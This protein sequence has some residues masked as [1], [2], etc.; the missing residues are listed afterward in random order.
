M[1]HRILVSGSAGF[2]GTKLCQRLLRDGHDVIGV[3]SLVEQVHHGQKPMIPRGM[4]FY[5]ADIGDREF[6]AKLLK[7]HSID[8]IFHEAAE[9]GVAQSMYEINQY[10]H[11]NIDATGALMDVLAK[12][13]H[14]VKKIMVAGSAAS[15]GE[16]SY[17]CPKCATRQFPNPRTD[18]SMGFEYHCRDCQTQLEIDYIRESDPV[19]P[20]SIYGLTKLVQEQL[21]L[22]TGQ[23]YGIDAVALR[24]FNIMGA[25]QSPTNPYTGVATLFMSRLKENKAPLVFEDGKQVRDFVSV[26][27][28]VNANVLAMNSTVKN[29]TFNI[30]GGQR[31]TVT[32]MVRKLA[33]H[34]N[35][36]IEPE[37]T[38]KFRKGDTR[39]LQA[40]ITAAKWALDYSPQHTL[41]DI[42]REIVEW[43]ETIKTEDHTDRAFAELEKHGMLGG[44]ND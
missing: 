31:N 34:M 23:A 39:H 17:T 3:D 19:R 5:H 35:K 18:V 37:I 42:L 33:L 25:G 10:V 2:L 24:Y 28:I 30:G 4:D 32:D 27:D 20:G 26:H 11:G 12:S 40:D 36:P 29:G 9:V 1:K 14:G 15:Y 7:E 13:N 6:V 44:R 38:G 41:D 43:S 22:M 21:V 16:G 8:V